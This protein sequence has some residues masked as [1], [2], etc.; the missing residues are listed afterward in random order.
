MA[1]R[2][3]EPAHLRWRAVNASHLVTLVRPG[4][5][6]HIGRLVERPNHP[7][8]SAGSPGRLKLLIHRS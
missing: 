6:F 7:R 5:R 8:I 2:V 3:V 4:A 1:F